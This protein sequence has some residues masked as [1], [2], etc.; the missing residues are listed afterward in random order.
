MGK[1][2]TIGG[3]RAL[4]AVAA[5]LALAAAGVVLGEA[6]GAAPLRAADPGP[7]AGAGRAPAGRVPSPEVTGPVT[8]GTHGRPF[9]SSPV[10]LGL[11]G[12]TEQE[13]FLKGTATGYAP[14]GTWGSDGNWAARPAETAPYETRILVRRPA[15][16][17]RFN[18]TVVVEWLNVSFNVDI[19]PDFL[20]ESQELVRAGYAWVGVSAQQAGVEG[21]LGLKNWDPA[22]Y[23]AL[24]HPGDTFSYSIF[25]QAAEALLHPRGPH[26]LGPLHPRVL[27]ADGESQS[28]SR[29]VTYANAI[30]PLT[31]LFGGFLI[32]SRGA[33]GA[34]ISQ[35]PQAAP[36]APAVGRIR[37]DIG[38][39]VLT[40][41]TQTDI[42]PSGLDYLPATQPDSRWFRLWEVAGT[43]HVDANE[44]GLSST[45]VLRDVPGFPQG[46]CADAPNDGQERYVMDAA[47]V[48]LN[49]WIRTGGPAPH[50]ARIEIS[51]GSYVTDR[52]GNALGGVRTPAVDAPVATLT[53]TGNTGSSLLCFL[54]GTSTPL[55]AAQLAALYPLH[56]DYVAAVARSAAS[57]VREGFLLPADALQIDQDAA[58]SPVGLPAPG[59]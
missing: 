35:A 31:R 17:A 15:N 38:V 1:N 25:A 40:V 34:P 3:A 56:S 52:F 43:S 10:P 13:F 51:G 20:Y 42:V 46:S 16:P 47:V 21:P 49:R 45:E 11:A 50:A 22:R 8:G 57:D 32:H 39:P 23:G 9:T 37:T 36:P 5:G 14:A 6:A 26:P 2:G 48:Q 53:G 33:A 24:S 30:Q 4:V 27:I 28:A 55:S 41:E 44:L 29:M 54:L 7:A 12:Y 59:G 19:D 58:A 18:G